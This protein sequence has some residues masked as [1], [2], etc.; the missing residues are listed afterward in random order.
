MN[1]DDTADIKDVMEGLR[2]AMRAVSRMHNR[3]S[4]SDV[5]ALLLQAQE[6]FKKGHSIFTDMLNEGKGGSDVEAR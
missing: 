1:R 4:D 2:F 3:C 6:T 5:R